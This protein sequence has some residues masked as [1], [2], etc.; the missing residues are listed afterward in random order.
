MRASAIRTRSRRS[1]RSSR[2]TAGRGRSRRST[3]DTAA[4]DALYAKRADFV[5]HV[6]GLGGHRGR[7]TRHRASDLRLR[8]LRVPGLLPGRPR[9]R[10]RVAG[11][12][13][14][15]GPGVRRRDGRAA[16]SSPRGPGRRGGPAG[17]REP[18]RLR[19]Q[20][21]LPARASA[22]WP[23]AGISST[24]SGAVGRQTLDQWQG[25]SGF[26]FDQGLLVGPD[27][28]PLTVAPDYQAL[29]TNDYLHD[30]GARPARALGPAAR[31]RRD[32]APAR[33][34]PTSGSRTS[35]RSR[36]RRRRASWARCGTSARR[37]SVTSS[38]PWSRR[39]SAV[40]ISV[41]LAIGAAV[42][43]DRWGPVRRAVEPFLVTSQTIPIVAIAP[44]FVIWFGFGLLPKVLIVVLVTFFPVTIALL[45][46][47]G[48]VDPEAMTL[49][50]SLGAI[51]EPDLPQASMA[52]GLA[53]P[54]HRSA[55]QRRLR[56]HR[57]HLRRVRRRDRRARDLDEAVAEQLPDG[58]R[59][60]RDPAVGDRVGRP[61]HRRRRC[62]ERVVVPWAPRGRA[63]T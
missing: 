13:A 37:R 8:R 41:V 56:R 30:L 61:V 32:R 49:M 2:R 22:S 42:A 15:A 26:L 16:S 40:A 38:R 7:G 25:Y 20:P 11:G 12:R 1:G 54:V 27:G 10:P 29:F 5:D 24:T 31:A 6:R 14:G 3:L 51:G 17:L 52:V 9:L 18:G 63:R 48:R 50:R 35:T 62:V 19:R 57:R 21:E 59:L 44:L 46:G 23:R 28:K 36:C 33:G 45:D 4:Y 43:L 60:R 53:V 47:F 39:S 55:D 34:R 58:P